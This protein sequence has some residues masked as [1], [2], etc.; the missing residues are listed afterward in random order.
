MK[1]IQAL[2]KLH[3]AIDNRFYCAI[4]HY[5][6]KHS[7]TIP[8]IKTVIEYI[9]MCI[10]NINSLEKC[11][12]VKHLLALVTLSSVV[13]A[14]QS[15]VSGGLRRPW[16]EDTGVVSPACVYS[17]CLPGAFCRR[18]PRQICRV[19]TISELLLVWPLVLQ[20]EDLQNLVHVWCRVRK[21]YQRWGQS[22]HPHT[23]CHICHTCVCIFI[24]LIVSKN[25]NPN[26]SN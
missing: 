24:W 25:P 7:W 18:R 2:Q 15:F 16:T 22:S 8:Q 23:L 1:C 3:D 19:Q 26:T 14:Y 21:H 20:N 9:A 12:D 17:S 6:R 13:V 5:T 10:L 4:W 11:T